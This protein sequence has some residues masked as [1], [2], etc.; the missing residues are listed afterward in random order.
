MGWFS[1]DKP[2]HHL[3]FFL[4]LVPFLPSQGMVLPIWV[5]IPAETFGAS[6]RWGIASR[7]PGGVQWKA[8]FLTHLYKGYVYPLRQLGAVNSWPARG[9]VYQETCLLMFFVSINSMSRA[10]NSLL[11]SREKL[12]VVQDIKTTVGSSYEL[13][14]YVIVPTWDLFLKLPEVDFGSKV[15]SFL[16][17]SNT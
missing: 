12:L 5:E 11:A 6:S 14:F 10:K 8:A 13:D 17:A 2:S 7:T 1:A 3:P 4:C 16:F 15:L 9:A